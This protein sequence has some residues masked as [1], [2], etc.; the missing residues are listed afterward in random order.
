VPTESDTPETMQASSGFCY[1]Y[2]I[3]SQQQILPKAASNKI[4]IAVGPGQVFFRMHNNNTMTTHIHKTV[5]QGK[6]G[7]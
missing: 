2:L 4:D 7:K 6:K 3:A 5:S 1:Q